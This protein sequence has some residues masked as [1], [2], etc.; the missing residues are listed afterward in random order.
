MEAKLTANDA[1][2]STDGVG[3]ISSTLRSALAK[4]QE[5]F[6]GED[7]EADIDDKAVMGSFGKAVLESKQCDTDK[8]LNASLLCGGEVFYNRL[9]QKWVVDGKDGCVIREGNL[10]PNLAQVLQE[11]T[12]GK[13]ADTKRLD[14]MSGQVKILVH[15]DDQ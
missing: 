15:N 12:K 5:N 1:L 11:T 6:G 13:T 9:R 10:T 8:D 4:T 2:I 14:Y 3:L 7:I